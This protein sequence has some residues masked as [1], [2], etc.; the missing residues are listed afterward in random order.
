[1]TKAANVLLKEFKKRADFALIFRPL[2]LEQ[3]GILSI[4]D[5]SLG[6]VTKEGGHEGEVLEKL[7]SQSAYFVVL[8]DKSLM[9]GKEGW[10]NVLDARSHRLPRVCRST[11]GAELMGVEE[12]MD[13]GIY[14]RGSFADFRGLPMGR[15]DALRVMEEIPFIAVTDAKDTYDRSN[16]DCPTYGAQK[17]MAF[18]V[19]W[20]RQVLHGHNSSLKWTAT[21]NM[22]VDAGT[23]LMATD[24]THDILDRGKWSYV[25]HQS[26]VKQPARKKVLASVSGEGELPGT[27]LDEKSPIFQFVLSLS[28]H[29][30]WRKRDDMVAHVALGAKSFRVPDARFGT[31]KFPWRS[32][33][34]RF[35]LEDGRSVWRELEKGKNLNEMTVRQGLLSRPAHCL[36]SIFMSQATKKKDSLKK[37]SCDFHGGLDMS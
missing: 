16:S 27:A 1:M 21:A 6:N 23:K 20:I 32:S 37:A 24:R 35:D 13:M 10:F 28:Y 4:S 12:G 36:I 31:T 18:S 2:N 3:A 30:G 22:W 15:R 9:E 11:Y 14:C 33:F 17:L 7:Y 19:A 8:A 29:P 26:Y 25:F 34:G 5:S